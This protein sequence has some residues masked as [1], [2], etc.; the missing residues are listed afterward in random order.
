MIFYSY[1]ALK[2]SGLKP[3]WR[4][5][6]DHCGL[7]VWITAENEFQALKVARSKSWRQGSRGCFCPEHR[8]QRQRRIEIKDF[9]EINML[10][11]HSMT[12]KEYYKRLRDLKK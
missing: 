12:V 1:E 4:F 7:E 10:T 8:S 9:E 11:G 2:A 6:C 5:T 3:W